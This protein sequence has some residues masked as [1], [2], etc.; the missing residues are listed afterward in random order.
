MAPISEDHLFRLLQAGHPL[1][2]IRELLD[3]AAEVAK[4]LEDDGLR[5]RLQQVVDDFDDAL[6]DLEVE[7]GDDDREAEANEG[8]PSPS[9]FRTLD[10]YRRARRRH[11]EARRDTVGEA[12]RRG[13][14]PP[15]VTRNV[16]HDN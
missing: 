8:P 11:Y 13:R 10:E 9:S 15:V 2:R 5:N 3:E 6:A 16:Q 14:T 1:A 7:D 4:E 12:T